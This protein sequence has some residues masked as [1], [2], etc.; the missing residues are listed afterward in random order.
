MFTAYRWDFDNDGFADVYFDG[1]GSLGEIASYEWYEGATHVASSMTPN[2]VP[3][4]IGEHT[5]TLNI[6]DG[7]EGDT[8]DV[9]VKVK[10]K[11]GGGGGGGNKCNNPNKPGCT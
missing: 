3:L 10:E 1:S 9:V 2:P 7:V 6:S 8:D 11:K 4:A 5:I